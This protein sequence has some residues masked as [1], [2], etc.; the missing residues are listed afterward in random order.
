VRADVDSTGQLRNRTSTDHLKNCN[1]HIFLGQQQARTSSIMP[2]HALS[3]N[4]DSPKLSQQHQ[5][6]GSK[7][8][9]AKHAVKS[10]T[11]AA[12]CDHSSAG[13]LSKEEELSSSS[14][15]ENKPHASAVIIKTD[16]KVA[17]EKGFQEEE[18][19]LKENPHRFVIFP[20]QDN[21]VSLQKN[22]RCCVPHNM[23]WTLFFL[24]ITVLIFPPAD[25]ENVQA[26]RSKLLDGRRD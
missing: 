17:E 26:S 22:V 15:V 10:I 19:L 13:S 4:A 16:H 25:L 11:C 3:T 1:C 6:E 12:D 9:D 2:L 24:T 20:I 23:A 14:S 8:I 5:L 18:P 7:E 21:D